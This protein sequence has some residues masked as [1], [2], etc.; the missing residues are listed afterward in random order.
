[1]Q[2]GI[3]LEF[4][5]T[6]QLCLDDALARAAEAGYR[7]VE[8]YVYSPVSVPINSHLVLQGTTPYHHINTEEVDVGRLNRLKQELALEFSAIDAHA[9]LL[10][11]QVGV[12][13][14]RRAIELAAE[15]E[16]PV[17]MSD[18]GPVPEQ[19]MSLQQGFDIMCVSLEAIIPHARSCGVQ[20]AIE[21]HNALTARPDM[22]L[23]LLERF[24]ADELGVNFDTGNSFLAGNDPVEYLRNVAQRVIHVHVKDIPRYQLHQRGKVTGTRVGVAAG[25]GVVD[26]KGI[27]GVLAEVVYDGVLSIECDSLE[28]ARKSLPYMNRVFNE[29]ENP[30][31]E[32]HR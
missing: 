27:V 17:V 15:V 26:L 24:G 11:P 20:F 12:P 29:T 28:Q 6:E 21:L 16:C 14:L 22:L 9:S 23:K 2:A 3:N 32:V 31:C 10:L 8:P 7:F 25:D 30:T 19:W 13:Y 4:A 1:M 5:R 18:E